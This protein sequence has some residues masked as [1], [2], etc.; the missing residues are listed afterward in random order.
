MS[1]EDYLMLVLLK[2]WS[3]TVLL[4]KVILMNFQS[5]FL[6]EKYI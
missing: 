6:M 4:R 3:T 5:K 2:Y 1:Y